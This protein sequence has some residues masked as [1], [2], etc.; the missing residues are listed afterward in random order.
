M[1]VFFQNGED[2]SPSSDNPLLDEAGHGSP[3]MT[4]DSSQRAGSKLRPGSV[5]EPLLRQSRGPAA[6]R[7]YT[8]E[9]SL[10]ELTCRLRILPDALF[11]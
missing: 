6:N 4:T 8:E 9:V 5:Q 1:I 3:S 10:M 2:S 7:Q 11:G